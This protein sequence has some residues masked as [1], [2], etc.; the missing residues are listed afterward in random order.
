M[1]FSE[2]GSVTFSRDKQKM[3]VESAMFS[4]EFGTAISVKDTQ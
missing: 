3:K 4:T 2:S 1:L